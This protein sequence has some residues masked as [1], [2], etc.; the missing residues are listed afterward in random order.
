MDMTSRQLA[1]EVPFR[2]DR[3]GAIRRYHLTN[4]SNEPLEGISLTLHGAGVMSA[5]NPARLFPG[6][7]LEVAVVGR[8]LARNTILVVRWFRPNGTEYLWRI[9]F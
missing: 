7:S 8:D 3:N 6:E 1:Y 5:S 2:L 4:I 9:S